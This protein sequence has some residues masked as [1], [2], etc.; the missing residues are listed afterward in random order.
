MAKSKIDWCD[1][2]WNPVTG[3]RHGCPYCYAREFVHRFGG[4]DAGEL[5]ELTE[6]VKSKGKKLVYPFGFD[7]TC[8][9]YKLS[10]YA[11]PKKEGRTIFVCSMADL[12]GDWVPDEWITRVFRACRQAPQ[13]TYLFLTKNPRRYGKLNDEGILPADQNMFFGCTVTDQESY[14]ECTDA[15][16]KGLHFINN[17]FLSIEPLRGRIEM[18][19]PRAIRLQCFEWVIIGAETGNHPDKVTPQ[20]EWIEE[21]VEARHD[22][23]SHLPLFMKDNLSQV[24]GDNLIREYTGMARRTHRT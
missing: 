5:H 19:T 21:I 7:P 11:G 12:F 16:K 24:W 1:D 13:H 20:R 2:T 14:D 22:K 9:E 23:F 10:D 17:S 3:C 6:P 15:M 18:T 8:Y 4:E